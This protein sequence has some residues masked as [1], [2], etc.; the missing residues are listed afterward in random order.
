MN[1]LASRL[2][3]VATLAV[4]GCSSA[5]PSEN[6]PSG[7]GAED[8]APTGP[9]TPGS[10]STPEKP[11]TPSDPPSSRPEPQA[12]VRDCGVANTVPIA[13][14][15]RMTVPQFYQTPKGAYVIPGALVSNAIWATGAATRFSGGITGTSA[16]DTDASRETLL[17]RLFLT[18]A[19]SG[20]S[21]GTYSNA[22]DPM[23][24][25]LDLVE[26]TSNAL[27]Y[28]ESWGQEELA[29]SMDSPTRTAAASHV[30]SDLFVRGLV[31]GRFFVH[32]FVLLM[33]TTCSVGALGDALGRK[34]MLTDSTLQKGIFESSKASAVQD[35]LVKNG[36]KLLVRVISNKPVP[37]VDTLLAS[38]ECSPA[39]LAACKQLATDL[40]AASEQ[41]MSAPPSDLAKL[42]TGTDPAW[43][44]R[45]YL[46][47]QVSI[48]AD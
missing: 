22:V 15:T 45:G 42:Q 24:L 8:P 7:P 13:L 6:V 16:Q 20:S 37:A 26:A 19:R 4:V 47:A 39:N 2:A 43:T 21:P 35:V 23:A 40:H 30:G 17:A 36:A 12:T 33:P 18:D 48:L 46:A 5:A 1:T 44:T 11:G 14:D 32:Q 28:A 3:V 9:A 38:T 31:P 27:T 25:G 34:A 10:G 41:L 29:W